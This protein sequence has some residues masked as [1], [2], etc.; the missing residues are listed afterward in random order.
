MGA[1]G[2]K[3]RDWFSGS[4]GRFFQSVPTSARYREKFSI[5]RW[6]KICET[7]E[8]MARA[9]SR[10]RYV[11]VTGALLEVLSRL[12]P[13][14][15]VL[16]ILLRKAGTASVSGRCELRALACLSN[17]R[18]LPH[19]ETIDAVLMEAVL[20]GELNLVSYKVFQVWCKLARSEVA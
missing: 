6:E 4:T 11:A 9:M 1:K 20:V 19:A 17:S 14:S 5:R 10:A 16:P 8:G 12:A 13:I 18:F 15:K 7:D 2:K 3:N